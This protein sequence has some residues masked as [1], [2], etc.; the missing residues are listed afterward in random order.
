MCEASFLFYLSDRLLFDDAVDSSELRSSSDRIPGT[1]LRVPPSPS[2][3]SLSQQPTAI[4]PLHLSINQIIKITHNFSPAK[5]IGDGGFGTVYKADLPD[6]RPIA[7]KRAKKVIFIFLPIS[8]EIH[9][10]NCS[11]V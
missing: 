10:I 8:L 4:G 9:Q 11:F 7:I 5:V 6:G 2:R 3:F 1:P